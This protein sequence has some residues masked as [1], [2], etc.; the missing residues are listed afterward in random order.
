MAWLDQSDWR[1]IELRSSY[2]LC[3]PSAS[4]LMWASSDP[5]FDTLYAYGKL[6]QVNAGP[7]FAAWELLWLRFPDNCVTLTLPS[8][9]N[10]TAGGQFWDPCCIS[11]IN[12]VPITHILYN[13]ITSPFSLCIS[14]ISRET[15]PIGRVHANL[16]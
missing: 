3:M 14:Q 15:E 2:A 1:Q 4:P 5:G 11:T 6:T 9:S 16:L 7:L 8:V 12:W 10:S 13:L